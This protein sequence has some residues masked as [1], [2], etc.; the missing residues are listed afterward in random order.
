[1]VYFQTKNPNLGKFWRALE[2]K[3]FWSFGVFSGHLEYFRDVWYILETFGIFY[4]TLGSV[5]IIWYI[6]HRFE[7]LC[8]EKYGNPGLE[9]VGRH[10][11]IFLVPS[12]RNTWRLGRHS[13]CQLDLKCFSAARKKKRC[14]GNCE[15]CSKAFVRKTFVDSFCSKKLLLVNFVRKNVC[16]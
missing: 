1:M 2:W 4:G 9:L 5:V 8:Q 16:W 7:I 15:F 12:G 3:M 10:C 11:L 14:Q 13:S 6:F